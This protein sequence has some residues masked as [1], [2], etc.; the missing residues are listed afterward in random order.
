M[1]SEE[2]PLSVPGENPT[3]RFALRARLVVPVSS[4]P[5][6]GG[7]ITIQGDRIVAIGENLT[8]GPPWDWGDVAV[9]PGLINPHTHLELSDCR[10]PLG[11]AGM[12]FP[13]WIHA[14]V[15]Q[16]RQAAAALGDAWPR[17]RQEAIQ[18]GLNASLRGGVTTVGDIATWDLSEFPSSCDTACVC[19]FREVMGLSGDRC[20]EQLAIARRHIERRMGDHVRIDAALSP[21]APYTA[22]P[23]LVDEVA[24]LSRTH[25]CNVAM[26]LAESEEELELLATGTGP[27]RD[28]LQSLGAWADTAFRGGVEPI[29]YLRRLSGAHR[30]LIIHGNY[31]NPSEWQFLAEHRTSMTAVYCPRTHHYFRHA[32]YPLSQL[33]QSGV[34][35]AIGTD[36]C[37]SSPNLNMFEELRFAA[38]LH[39][40]VAPRQILQLG[41]L[42]AAESLGYARSV[43][44]L[45]CGKRADLV[46]VRIETAPLRKRDPYAVLFDDASS[47]C[48]TYCNGVRC[49]G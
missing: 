7:V 20:A 10:T 16:R 18:A 33:L 26:H 29:D 23:E 40:D 27:F 4:P 19:V 38:R 42:A 30:S 28:T 45:E 49:F 46:I 5:I 3:T 36:S 41:T 8:S 12:P 1:H 11:A 22:A 2:N 32:R 14:L 39:S 9:M 6:D 43:G 35:L 48:A 17:R 34:R 24:A 31:L 21:H 13:G 47:V 37:A 25:R 44:S 15:A